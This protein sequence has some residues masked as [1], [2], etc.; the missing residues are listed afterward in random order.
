MK[1]RL[2]PSATYKVLGIDL[3]LYQTISPK[4]QFVKIVAMGGQPLINKIALL[5][6]RI[7]KTVELQTIL[8]KFVKNLNNN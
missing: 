4:L 3:D 8:Q 6:E 7:A 1:S 2:R 5:A